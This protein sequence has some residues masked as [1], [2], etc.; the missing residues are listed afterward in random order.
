MFA[1]CPKSPEPLTQGSSAAMQPPAC[2]ASTQACCIACG[3]WRKGRWRNYTDAHAVCCVVMNCLVLTR[4]VSLFRFHT[5]EAMAGLLLAISLRLGLF[6]DS[7]PDPKSP[8]RGVLYHIEM[9]CFSVSA[10]LRSAHG[11]SGCVENAVMDGGFQPCWISVTA[12]LDSR[13]QQLWPSFS[14]VPCSQR[15]EKCIYGLPWTQPETTH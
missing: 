10:T 11:E 2:V 6:L 13:A 5:Y 1:H 3:T 12:V 9:A 4:E 7:I 14:Y 15:P 8:F